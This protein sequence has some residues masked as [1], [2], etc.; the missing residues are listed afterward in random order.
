MGGAE[1]AVAGL[2]ADPE[3]GHARHPEGGGEVHGTAVAGDEG[4]EPR[5]E[6]A[7]PAD[8]GGRGVVAPRP[9]RRHEVEE[10]AYREPELW[11]WLAAQRLQAPPQVVCGAPGPGE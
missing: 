3:D 4:V 8:V 1:G 6:G 10:R 11:E 2:V 5:E 9:G 7:E